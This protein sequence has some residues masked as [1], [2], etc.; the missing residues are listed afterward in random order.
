M[1]EYS[2]KT[3]KADRE[4]FGPDA[5]DQSCPLWP[6]RSIFAC[7][8]ASATGRWEAPATGRA[9]HCTDSTVS[10]RIMGDFKSP[11]AD[12]LMVGP[13]HISVFGNGYRL[14]HDPKIFFRSEG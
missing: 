9:T 13:G 7:S 12:L 2:T 5:E 14:D 3:T 4:Y 1:R 6:I 10:G 11:R 8:N